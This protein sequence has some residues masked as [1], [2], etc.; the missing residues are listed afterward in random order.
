VLLLRF[1]VVLCKHNVRVP[2]V[3]VVCTD[4]AVAVNS[5]PGWIGGPGDYALTKVV[6]I[7]GRRAQS[8]IC[9]PTRPSCSALPAIEP[10]DATVLPCAVDRGGQRDGASA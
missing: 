4:F 1:G 9:G 10:T 2:Y 3:S 6:G 5:S 7:D 8:N